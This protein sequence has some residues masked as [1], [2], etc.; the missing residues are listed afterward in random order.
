MTYLGKIM[1]VFGKIVLQTY[2]LM[3]YLCTRI[4]RYDKSDKYRF[5]LI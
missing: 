4:N 5:N 3:Y 2:F 1:A